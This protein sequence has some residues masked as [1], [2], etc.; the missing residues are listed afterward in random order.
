MPLGHRALRYPK[1]H[2]SSHPITRRHHQNLFSFCWERVGEQDSRVDVREQAGT[3]QAI[4]C[5][6]AN[7]AKGRRVT[8]GLLKQS[9]TWIDSVCSALRLDTRDTA[10]T[11]LGGISLQLLQ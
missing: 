8:D 4:L 2:G 7:V 9:I 10:M 5:T 11:L 6:I 1:G 3:T